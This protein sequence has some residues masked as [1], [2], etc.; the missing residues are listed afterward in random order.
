MLE[1][2]KPEAS[3]QTPDQRA[4]QEPEESMTMNAPPKSVIAMWLS[5]L[6]VV[7]GFAFAHVS[8][9]N[10]IQ[11]Q[12]TQI[13]LLRQSNAQLGK[14]LESIEAKLDRLMERK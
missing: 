3:E 7:V 5:L 9:G 12:D 13:Q 4:E 14:Q 6:A 8:Q 10:Q 11:S 1:P 2:P